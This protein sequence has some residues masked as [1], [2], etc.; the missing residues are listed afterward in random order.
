MKQKRRCLIFLLLALSGF[1]LVTQVFRVKE[2]TV[3]GAVLANEGS[4][5]RVIGQPNLLWLDL[6]EL[7]DRIAQDSFIKKASI[8]VVGLSSLR[9][10][11]EER[12]PA[13]N[14]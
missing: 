10:T 5:R 11:I 3:V 8:E 12:K 13:A 9:V 1:L 14:F 4:I 7:E 6:K 2:V